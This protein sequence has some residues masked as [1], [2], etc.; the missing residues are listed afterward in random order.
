MKSGTLTQVKL[1]WVFKLYIF[2]RAL[3]LAQSRSLL[4]KG[5][6]EAA[7]RRLGECGPYHFKTAIKQSTKGGISKID[8]DAL[9][10]DESVM[11]KAGEL[12]PPR[13]IDLIKWVVYG[14]SLVPKILSSKVSRAISRFKYLFLQRYVCNHSFCLKPRYETNGMVVSFLPQLLDRVTICKR[15]RPSLSCVLVRNHSSEPF[16]AFLGAILS[17]VKDVPV[18]R[19]VYSSDMELDII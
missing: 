13:C 6:F 12:L 17:V 19:S 8:Y 15:W 7:R 11:K 10:N 5:L 1:R 2:I 18:E 9:V 4:E 16:R 3:T 14:Q